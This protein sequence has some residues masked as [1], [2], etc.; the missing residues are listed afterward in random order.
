M[1]PNMAA[2]CMKRFIS[3]IWSHFD[4]SLAL[5]VVAPTAKW[6][7]NG[8]FFIDGLHSL[9]KFTILCFRS[10]V[11]DASYLDVEKRVLQ[12]KQK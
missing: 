10:I 12:K 8:L 9:R 1:V 2:K 11:K 7:T 6:S 4:N 3:L 5:V